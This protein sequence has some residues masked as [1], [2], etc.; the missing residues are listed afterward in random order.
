MTAKLHR[1]AARR[2]QRG[3]SMLEYALIGSVLVS[4][5]FVADYNGQT[6]AEFLAAEIRLFFRNMTFFVSLP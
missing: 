3:Q 1:H 6:I 5:L 4:A 2:H